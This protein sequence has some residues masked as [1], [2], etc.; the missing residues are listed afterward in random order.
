MLSPDKKSL[1][2]RIQHKDNK[3]ESLWISRTGKPPEFKTVDENE[4][5]EMMVQAKKEL[6]SAITAG[7][8]EQIERDCPCNQTKTTTTRR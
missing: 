7:I 2:L 4:W 8:R 1:G 5:N 3:P 6:P